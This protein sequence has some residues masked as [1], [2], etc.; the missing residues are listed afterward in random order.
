MTA[1]SNKTYQPGHTLNK[2]GYIGRELHVVSS[3]NEGNV[4]KN[5]NIGNTRIKICDDY[6]HDTTPETVQAIL[7]RIAYQAQTQL[8]MQQTTA[9]S[10]I[11]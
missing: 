4:V 7:D 9:Q 11:E 1:L 5:F 6:C 3:V 10:H 8:A 2:S